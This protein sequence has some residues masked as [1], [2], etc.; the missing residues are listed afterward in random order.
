MR[1]SRGL[2]AD[3][4][5]T[6]LDFDYLTFSLRRCRAPGTLIVLNRG[7][8]FAIRHLPFVIRNSPISRSPIYLFAYV[9]STGWQLRRQHQMAQ[10]TGHKS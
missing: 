4:G 9:A 3:F 7:K 8:L 2:D 6:I 5:F 10:K 1:I